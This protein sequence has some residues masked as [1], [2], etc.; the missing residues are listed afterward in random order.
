MGWPDVLVIEFPR[1]MYLFYNKVRIDRAR[2]V[3]CSANAHFNAFECIDK[4]KSNAFECIDKKKNIKESS[5]KKKH[6]ESPVS[7]SHRSKSPTSSP[8]CP[9][10]A[11]V[12]R[13]RPSRSV[14]AA[15]RRCT[16]AKIVRRSTGSFTRKPAAKL[17]RKKQRCCAC[18]KRLQGLSRKCR[19][20]L[21]LVMCCSTPWLRW[22]IPPTKSRSG[23]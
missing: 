1:C 20:L 17:V 21:Q 18:G 14:P 2:V 5:K 19:R 4:K 15:S 13:R 11:I 23:K 8:P 16:A 3:G 10:A 6:E 22:D 12:D 9:N 7:K